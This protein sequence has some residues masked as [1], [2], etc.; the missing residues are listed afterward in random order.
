MTSI[1]QPSAQ[2]GRYDGRPLLRLLDCYILDAIEQLPAS[3][4]ATLEKLEPTFQKAFGSTGGWREIVEEQIGFLPSV[5]LQIELLWASYQEAQQRLGA[6][7]VAADFVRDF[8]AQ[9][10]PDAREN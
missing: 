5:K 3:Q 6:K 9:N 2:P 4:I 8:V 1:P 10:V 7:V